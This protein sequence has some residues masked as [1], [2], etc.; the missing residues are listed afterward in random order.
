MS[1]LKSSVEE[2][3]TALG[4]AGE[5]NQELETE[6]TTLK[7]VNTS[8]KMALEEAMGGVKKLQEDKD[9][10]GIA[11]SSLEERDANALADIQSCLL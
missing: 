6:V 4:K 8:T 1:V 5:R 11:V 3:R 9:A 2:M 7:S 10:L